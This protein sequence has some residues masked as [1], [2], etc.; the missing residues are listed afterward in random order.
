MDPPGSP[1]PEM[2]F[3]YAFSDLPEYQYHAP[4]QPARGPA[5]LDDS[6]SNML[7]SFFQNIGTSELDNDNVFLDKSMSNSRSD[8]LGYN[9]GLDLAPAFDNSTISYPP[10]QPLSHNFP[11]TLPQAQREG[12]GSIHNQHATAATPEVLAAAST[13]I[14]N[15]QNRPSS[16][17]A[18]EVMFPFAESN[19]AFPDTHSSGSSSRQQS[20]GPYG[21]AQSKMVHI[22]PPTPLHPRAS[23]REMSETLFQEMYYGNPQST[24]GSMPYNYRMAAQGLKWG[25]DKSFENRAFVA[26]P[27][28]E[29]E[30]D[31]T[32]DMMQK[33]ECLERQSSATNTAPPS[34]LLKKGLRHQRRSTVI[35]PV[36]EDPMEE[37]PD[38]WEQ[39]P[40]KRKKARFKE[41]GEETEQSNTPK[42]TKSRR[43]KATSASKKARKVKVSAAKDTPERRKSEASDTKGN[44]QNLS[45]EAKR[46][47]HIQSEQKRRDLIKQG[48]DDL[49]E[50]IPELHGGSFSKSVIL[51][52]AADWVDQMVQENRDLKLQLMSLKEDDDDMA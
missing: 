11:E 24:Q 31:V 17:T 33:L 48:F 32:Q 19:Y 29:T 27:E 25:S 49:G 9:W 13:L 52:Q 46:A 43:A 23:A 12:C 1:S 4:P 39:R 38:D 51:V 3:G 44:R 18:Q 28:Q 6:E 34:P 47:N 16:S 8:D 7:D 20:D 41:E 42:K 15:G 30:E 10:Q 45:E 26:P 35:D 40:Q 37:S 21:A 36:V 14:H 50:I 22:S 5:L 2:P